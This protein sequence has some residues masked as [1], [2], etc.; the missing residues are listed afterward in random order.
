[1]QSKEHLEVND[2]EPTRSYKTTDWRDKI[3]IRKKGGQYLTK[4]ATE[5][6]AKIN[7]GILVHEILASSK[8]E[9]DADEIVDRYFTEGV[10]GREEKLNIKDQLQMIFSNPKVQGWFNTQAEI[11]TEIPILINGEEQ[12]RPD[13]VLIDGNKAVIIDF[14]TGVEKQT[15]KNQVIEYCSVLQKMGYDSVEAYLLYI[16]RNKVVKVA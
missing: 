1:M 5:R 13:R 11:K 16:S 2:A 8:N 4:D 3:A 9:D 12:K 6:R 7:Y 15:D 14:K 10:I